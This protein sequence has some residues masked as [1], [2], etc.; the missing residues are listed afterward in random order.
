MTHAKEGFADY[1]IGGYFTSGRPIDMDRSWQDYGQ[2][3]AFF[4]AYVERHGNYLATLSIWGWTTDNPTA[5]GTELVCF[6]DG[7]TVECER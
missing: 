3:K 7:C 5:T 6:G 1:S 2:A 4:D